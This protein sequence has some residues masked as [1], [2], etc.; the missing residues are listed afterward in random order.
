MLLLLSLL[1]APVD[2][3]PAQ[4]AREAF[5]QAEGPQ[6]ASEV[7]LSR[8]V[9]AYV[10]LA[11]GNS[12]ELA[13][14][15]ARW[16]AAVRRIAVARR[17]PEPTLG[18]GVF[19]Q[20]VE[21][22]VGPQQARVTLQQTFPWPSSLSAGS[23][24]AAAEARAAE[25][26]FEAT[27]LAIEARVQSAYWTLWEIRE[28]RATHAE[29]LLTLSGLSDTLRGR[30]EV[31]QATLAD[32][33]QVELAAARMQDEIARSGAAEQ[34]AEA[35]LIA[36]TG[37]RTLQ[38]LPTEV[39]PDAPRVPRDTLET[40]TELAL[41]HPRIDEA[42]AWAE[43]SEANVR[44]AQAQ[45]LPGFTLGADWVLVGPASQPDML[46]PGESGKDALAASVGL[47][48]PLWQASYAEQI[49]S[50]QAEERAREAQVLRAEDAALAALRAAHSAVLDSARRVT[51][52]ERTL[53]PQAEALYGS[54]AGA[55]AS[56]RG[57]L[58]QVLLAQN[59]L[60]SLRIALRQAQ[61][62]HARAWAQLVELCGGS[63]PS[64]LLEEAP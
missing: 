19:L 3:R 47:R 17:L 29:H 6:A 7:E 39:G 11:M 22:R 13:L 4:D 59:E 44:R 43:V 54:M 26:R 50:A 15:W 62:E 53:L 40:L 18:L 16:E 21:T 10:A 49:A 37:D 32:L 2:A 58:A 42:Q 24:A 8:G 45:R 1:S 38:E 27:A 56:G 48:V 20:S 63:L 5:A 23:D 9:N 41:A 35:Q 30:L 51:L 64:R 36:I 60:L 57:S 14:A 28:T 52:V 46:A 33:Q 34:R 12:P 31:G 55:Y 25:A 61:A